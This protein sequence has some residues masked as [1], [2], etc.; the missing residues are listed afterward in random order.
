VTLSAS[1]H[2]SVRGALSFRISFGNLE[3]SSVPVGPGRTTFPSAILPYL[4]WKIDPTISAVSSADPV[5]RHGM[6]ITDRFVKSSR[7]V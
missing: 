2:A 3:R 6:L 1:A 5:H 7:V 4:E